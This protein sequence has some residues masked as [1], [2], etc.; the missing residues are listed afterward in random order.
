M[1]WRT[2]DIASLAL[3]LTAC[4]GDVAPPQAAARTVARPT[5]AAVSVAATMRARTPLRVGYVEYPGATGVRTYTDIAVVLE[6]EQVDVKNP[7]LELQ[8][9]GRTLGRIALA[10]PAAPGARY[11]ST[12]WSATIP[13]AWAIRGAS[14][15]AVADGSEASAPRALPLAD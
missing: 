7:A 2:L 10:R 5:L 4:G 8:A 1:H 3:L 9:A 6:L 12:H 14:W 15:R 13:A 11:A